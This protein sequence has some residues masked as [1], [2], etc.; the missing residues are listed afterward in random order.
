MS[1]LQQMT[2]LAEQ[3][4]RRAQS[5]KKLQQMRVEARQEIDR[6][7]RFL[8]QSDSYVMTELE[9]DVSA[10]LEDGGDAE[11]SLGSFDRMTDQTKSWRQGRLCEIPGIDAEQDDSDRE[12]DDPAE[13]SEPSGIGDRDGLLEQIGQQDWTQTVMA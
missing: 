5:I 9:D 3:E 2:G 7:I 1:P 8:D 13:D 10:E 12:D 6:L 4:A 11:P